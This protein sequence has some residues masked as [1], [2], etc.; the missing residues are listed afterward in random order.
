[1]AELLHGVAI[2][3]TGAPSKVVILILKGPESV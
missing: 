2:D 1:M 3:F